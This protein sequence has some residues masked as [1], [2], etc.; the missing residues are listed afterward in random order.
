M[1]Q[2]KK[3]GPYI[4]ECSLIDDHTYMIA[5]WYISD[6]SLDCELCELIHASSYEGAV[7]MWRSFCHNVEKL[8]RGVKAC[9]EWSVSS[10]QMKDTTTS[11]KGF[12]RLLRESNSY[13]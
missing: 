4:V 7:L 5:L 11:E 12:P 9:S 2:Y 8:V 6:R 13:E 1:I 3:I 10:D